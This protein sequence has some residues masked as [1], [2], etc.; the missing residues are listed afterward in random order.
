MTREKN[1]TNKRINPF[2]NIPKAR[3]DKQDATVRSEVQDV[4]V[5]AFN[6]VDFMKE[7]GGGDL[8][9]WRILM[10]DW[11]RWRRVETVADVRSIVEFDFGALAKIGGG[12]RLLVIRKRRVFKR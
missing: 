11:Y 1:A 12:E 8:E 2:E 6:G 10:I 5:T 3:T 4:S 7:S 9:S